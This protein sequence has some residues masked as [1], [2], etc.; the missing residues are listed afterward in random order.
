MYTAMRIIMR[1]IMRTITITRTAMRIP[2]RGIGTSKA[3]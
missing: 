2:R 3:L 1:T